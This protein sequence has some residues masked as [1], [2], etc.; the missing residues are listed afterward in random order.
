MSIFYR[1]L[2]ILISEQTVSVGAPLVSILLLL[3]L[4]SVLRY[5]VCRSSYFKYK[6]RFHLIYVE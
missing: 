5:R 1:K 4:K 3:K 2:D 6:V